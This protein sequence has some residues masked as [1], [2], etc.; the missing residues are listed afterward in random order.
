MKHPA[1]QARSS[2]IARVAVRGG[3]AASTAAVIIAGAAFTAGTAGAAVPATA[4]FTLNP[5][6]AGNVIAPAGAPVDLHSSVTPVTSYKGLTWTAS[7]FPS[8]LTM[9][10]STG[11]ITGIPHAPGSW[12]VKET[13]TSP[14]GTSRS[15]YFAVTI[16]HAA[17]YKATANG[18]AGLIRNAHS[19]K[20]LRVMANAYAAG[21]KIAQW[22]VSGKS[23]ETFEIIIVEG[24]SGGKVVSE[25]GY[26]EAIS[27]SG[28]KFYVVPDGTGQ[29][30][31]GPRVPARPDLADI[32]ASPEAMLKYGSYYPFLN[33]WNGDGADVMEDSGGT[34]NGT[35][36][37][38]YPQNDGKNQQWSMP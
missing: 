30:R 23:H 29:L 27:P 14:D 20:Y 22:D 9:N 26:L 28:A 32:A 17:T 34:A 19:G 4:G 21:S 12:T 15:V 5:P 7:G 36:V 3:A 2:V 16:T 33:D 18:H 13:A 6:E 24:T 31:L 1:R 37:I 38:A 8:S 35:P 25:A 10:A 11:A